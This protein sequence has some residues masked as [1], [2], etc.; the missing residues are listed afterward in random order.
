MPVAVL[1]LSSAAPVCAQTTPDKQTVQERVAELIKPMHDANVKN[2][3]EYTCNMALINFERQTGLDMIAGKAIQPSRYDSIIDRATKCIAEQPTPLA[4]D[5]RAKAYADKGESK[6]AFADFEKAIA[7]ARKDG[8]PVVSLE[9]ILEDRADLYIRL[10]DRAKA[11]ADLREAM[12]LNASDY[13]VKDKLDNL[14]R[15][16]AEARK[17]AA[18]G[19]P[20]TAEDYVIAGSDYDMQGK[21][22]DAIAA[23]SKS[24][25]LK[26]TAAAYVGKAKTYRTMERPETAIAELNQALAL[27]PKDVDAI[28]WRGYINRDLKRWDDA[29]ADFG[30][31]I[32]LADTK[33]KPDM[34]VGRGTGYA[35]KGLHDA[36]LKDFDAALASGADNVYTKI[37]ALSGKGDALRG[38]G[39]TA[40]ALTAYNAAIAAAGDD[41]I[42]KLNLYDAYMG[43]GRLYA[44]QGK[45]DMAKADFNAIL[46]M[47]PDSKEPKAEMAKLTAG[48]TTAGATTGTKTAIAWATDG[49]RAA[50]AKK[51]DEAIAAFT[52]CIRLAPDSAGCYAFRGAALGMKGDLGAS[53]TDFDKAL[54][55]SK[56]NPAVLF[57]RGQ[58]YAQLGRKPDA[59]ADFRAAQKVAPTNP[60]IAKALELLGEK[61]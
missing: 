52:E 33:T 37:N 17:K 4:Y 1:S 38:Q 12:K 14:D 42:A 31:A 58:M 29:I 9:A 11:E 16:I 32:T 3:Q 34:L 25:S 48:T 19:N 59:I 41:F 23:Y 43:R 18:I 13:S 22:N 6:P 57:M 7:I 8:S 28:K 44:S 24:I 60:Q 53:R 10:G 55:L 61:P 40:E 51:W 26:P 50:G 30:K 45:A 27:A 20:K 5:Y 47:M 35:A 21:Y 46:A 54:K 39:K 2:M 56:N 15:K 49:R 36:A